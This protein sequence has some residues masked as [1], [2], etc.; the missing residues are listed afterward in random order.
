MEIRTKTLLFITASTIILLAV[1]YTLSESILMG[2]FEEFERQNTGQNVERVLDAVDSERSDLNGIA[3]D[4]AAWDDTYKFIQDGNDAFILSNIHPEVFVN[5]R[6]NVMLFI[7]SS[8][9]VIFH[10]ALDLQ[11]REEIPLPQ[12]IEEYTT[13]TAILLSHDDLNGNMSGIISLPGGPM[14]V[15]SWP[16]VKSLGDGPVKGTLI[17]GRA[18]DGYEVGR[19]SKLTHL[20][21][22]METF[23]GGQSSPDF[24]EAFSQLGESP[25]IFIKPLGEDAIAGYALMKDV[26]GRPSVVFRVKM[27]RDVYQQSKTTTRY[28]I[29]SL[30]L[31]SIVFSAGIMMLLERVVLSRMAKLDDA[32]T[33][34][35]ASGDLSTRVPIEGEDELS[36][37]ASEMNRALS[38]LERSQTERQNVMEKLSSSEKLFHELFENS[39]DP[40]L[41]L[42]E[43]GGVLAA[44]T[45]MEETSGYTI[46]EM[47]AEGFVAKRLYTA[48][49]SAVVMMNLSK[50]FAGFYINPYEVEVVRKD[51]SVIPA[52]INS[53][54]ITFKGEKADLVALRDI[55]ERKKVESM[56]EEFFTSV[57]HEL[58]T[59]ITSIISFTDSLA[60]SKAGPVNEQQREVLDY[61]MQEAVRLKQHVERILTMSKLEQGI[62]MHMREADFEEVIDKVIRNFTPHA[63]EKHITLSKDVASKLPKVTCDVERMSDVV[64]NLVGNAVKFTR[65]GGSVVV[66]AREQN[67]C[68]LV[69]VSDTG[70]GIP[71]EDAGGIFTKFFQVDP[72]KTN[73]IGGSGLGLYICKRIVELHK[74]R[75]W[76]ESVPGEGT[77][78][79]F[80]LPLK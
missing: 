29:G 18:I 32:F 71:K 34:I 20:P 79:Y 46:Q 73:V 49:S 17:W 57:T 80:V 21:V 10:K 68:L 7:N 76:F 48:K 55:T 70:I 25:G 47:M 45:K 22:A 4:W 56:K 31:V 13:G 75:I 72:S 5:N 66:G 16:I 43:R 27:P 63:M 33:R 38:E 44:N 28:Y 30:L 40:L 9:N 14:L 37:L 42:D 61:V 2:S 24:E 6:I 50:R 39:V 1:L 3:R 62:E 74:G 41:V 52:E 19:I 77:T 60:N 53:R 8:G 51:K 23:S 58:K 59:P 54:L 12:G 35:G 64:N 26:Y 36:K 11:T 78:F 15:T 65:E 69:K 67:N